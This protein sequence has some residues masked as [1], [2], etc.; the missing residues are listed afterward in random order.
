[1]VNLHVFDPNGYSHARP[2]ID[3]LQEMPAAP[4]DNAFAVW[5]PFQKG[6]AAKTETLEQM[7]AVKN[8][9]AATSAEQTAPTPAEIA[10]HV[11]GGAS[12][13]AAASTRP[14]EVAEPTE[15]ADPTVAT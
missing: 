15:A 9:A 13:D 3:L 4:G 6:Q 10:P 2:S 7:L 11:D 8:S 1:M 14:A 5:M 12:T